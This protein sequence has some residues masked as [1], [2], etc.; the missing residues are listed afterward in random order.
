MKGP[1][2][3]TVFAPTDATFA[4][5]P[6]GTVDDLLK[7]GKQGESDQRTDL[8]RRAGQGEGG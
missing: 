6:A 2:P 1:G 8:S 4:K 7:A 5:L 3:F